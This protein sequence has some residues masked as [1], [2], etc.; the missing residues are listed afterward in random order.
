MRM[1]TFITV[2]GAYIIVCILKRKKN[3]EYQNFTCIAIIITAQ[4]TK[5]GLDINSMA[6]F[7]IALTDK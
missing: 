2:S 1:A 5:L 4:K 3:L 6:E 7:N